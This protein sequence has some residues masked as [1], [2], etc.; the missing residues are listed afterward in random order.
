MGLMAYRNSAQQNVKE[1]KGK[2][3]YLCLIVVF[4]KMKMFIKR[5]ALM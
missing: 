1:M 4:F 5:T 2:Q 3:M